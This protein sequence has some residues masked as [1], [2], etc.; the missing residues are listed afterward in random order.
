[1]VIGGEPVL[2]TLNSNRNNTPNRLNN[3][4][5]IDESPTQYS[6]AIYKPTEISP[7]LY[8]WR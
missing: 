7:P 4:P 8:G 3:D 2:I 5:S 1:M 6:A